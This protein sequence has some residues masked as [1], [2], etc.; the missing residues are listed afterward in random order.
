MVE[1]EIIE[2]YE[3]LGETRY[4]V[5]IRNTKIILNIS[6]STDRE[7]LNRAKELIKELKLYEIID[8]YKVKD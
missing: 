4:R 5:K 7:A 8:Q 1:L 2:K 3:L 6:A